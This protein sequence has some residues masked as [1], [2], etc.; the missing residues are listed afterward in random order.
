MKR[1]LFVLTSIIVMSMLILSSCKKEDP[2]SLVL[3][4]DKTAT[5]TGTVYA[6]LNLFEF[7]YETVSGK[8]IFIKVSNS[9]Y[10]TGAQGM[11]IYEV[12]TSAD[13]TYTLEVPVTDEGIYMTMDAAEFYYNQVQYD[14]STEQVSFYL[15][16]P[17]S[18]SNAITNGTYIRD[19]YYSY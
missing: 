11:T 17:P 12:T 2:T 1:K 13:G 19:I 8:T 10:L 3:D 9:E 6:E 7:G 18:V 4:T 16:F 15:S 5:I 14:E